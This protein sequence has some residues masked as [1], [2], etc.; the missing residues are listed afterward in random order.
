MESGAE[1]FAAAS[2][3]NAVVEGDLKNTM[4]EFELVMRGFLSFYF[5]VNHEWKNEADTVLAVLPT[6]FS[7]VDVGSA[8]NQR[9]S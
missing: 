8:T 5:S 3:K 7:F 6:I 2:T 9:I 1:E 4:V